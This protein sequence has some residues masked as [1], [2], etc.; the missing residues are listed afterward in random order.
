MTAKK[1]KYA[2]LLGKIRECG[3]THA[4]LAEKIGIHK[5]TLSA[6]LNNQFSFTVKEILAI[7]AALNIPQNEIGD[8]FFTD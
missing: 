6:K 4:D 1:T 3:L 5:G 8:Y 7:G 2:K